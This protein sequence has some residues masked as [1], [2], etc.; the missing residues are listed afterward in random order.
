MLSVVALGAVC[1]LARDPSTVSGRT[2]DDPDLAAGLSFHL[3]EFAEI[4]DG[5]RVMFR[6][7]RGWSSGRMRVA[8]GLP[9]PDELGPGPPS[10]PP[11][12]MTD[13]WQFETRQTLTKSVLACVDPDDDEEYAW[14]RA[15]LSELDVEVD[16]ASIRAAPYWVEF[17]PVLDQ[18]L[19]KRSR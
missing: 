5:R 3:G 17:G 18:Q 15:R 4:S 16:L 19:H 11:I 12:D 9:E 1:E 10:V 7:D 6:S 14:I 8:Y 13:P 2:L